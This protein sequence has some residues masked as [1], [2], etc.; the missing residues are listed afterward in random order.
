MEGRIKRET[1]EN[2][3]KI[4]F[5]MIGKYGLGQYREWTGSV[6]TLDGISVDSGLGQYKQW[7]ESV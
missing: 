3:I 4:E 5:S 7:T 1:W 2:N 6:K